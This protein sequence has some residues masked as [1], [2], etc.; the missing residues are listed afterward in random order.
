MSSSWIEPVRRPDGKIRGYKPRWREGDRKMSGPVCERKAE[1]RSYL[2]TVVVPQLH[3]T[4]STQ[5]TRRFTLAQWLDVYEVDVLRSDLSPSYKEWTHCQIKTIK[6]L[7]G[8]CDLGL[9]YSTRMS[10]RSLSGITRRDIKSLLL[11]RRD[12]G[13]GDHA[14][15][16][17]KKVLSKAFA[18]AFDAELVR[19]N[20]AEKVDAV[21]SRSVA[22]Q[23]PRELRALD[24]DADSIGRSRVPTFEVVEKTIE[25][26]GDIDT[27]YGV[28]GLLAAGA[29]LRF[30]E[31]LGLTPSLIHCIDTDEPKIQV[32][33]RLVEVSKKYVDGEMRHV[34]RPGTKAGKHRRRSA[35]LIP[36]WS[37]PIAEFLESR[38]PYQLCIFTPRN[39]FVSR[40]GFS[41]DVWRPMMKRLTVWAKE[42]D[43][44]LPKKYTF[45][46][47]RHW[48]ATSLLSAGVHVG[49]VA[50]VLGHSDPQ[51]TLTVYTHWLPEDP[52][53]TSAAL[54]TIGSGLRDAAVNS[55]V[56]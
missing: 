5:P 39:A 41:R 53:K 17:V 22:T 29:G 47:L 13:V 4:G 21:P 40:S 26:M 10:T 23:D 1:A 20:P 24:G 19:T 48:Y 27:T 43:Q 51:T 38:D 46:T 28:M 8:I 32:V 11:A 56:R 35:T 7:I 18:D 6:R 30:S 14:I 49:E 25:F 16:A 52:A 33:Q 34:L 2:E 50:R 37:P 3:R 45:H 12:E 15:S 36:Q 55:T 42:N 31:V 9:T 44:P 54:R